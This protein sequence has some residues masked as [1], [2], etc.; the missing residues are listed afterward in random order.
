M[1]FIIVSVLAVHITK[2]RMLY[3]VYDVVSLIMIVANKFVALLH[4]SDITFV[5]LLRLLH[6]TNMIFVT[7]EICPI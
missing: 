4:L 7:Y 3:F 2:I 5:C 6:M 1:Q